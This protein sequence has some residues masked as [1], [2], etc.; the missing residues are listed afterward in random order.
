MGDT[1]KRERVVLP[2]IRPIPQSVKN[3]KTRRNSTFAASQASFNRH[4]S[5]PKI[6][7]KAMSGS[8][9][10]FNVL[11]P[12]AIE[13]D[14]IIPSKLRV[15]VYSNTSES[16]MMKQAKREQRECKPLDKSFQEQSFN[17]SEAYT[18]TPVILV[19]EMIGGI[20]VLVLSNVSSRISFTMVGYFL[21]CFLTACMQGAI[22]KIL[23]KKGNPV[24]SFYYVSSIMF[25]MV[26]MGSEESLDYILYLIW[27][28]SMLTI[29]LQSHQHRVWKHMLSCTI[30]NMIL[31]HFCKFIRPM[32]DFFCSTRKCPTPVFQKDIIVSMSNLIIACAF[33]A[34]DVYLHKYIPEIVEEKDELQ[35]LVIDNLDLQHQ[36]RVANFKNES[37]II[38]PLTR[39]IEVLI[40]LQNKDS[41][42]LKTSSDITSILEMLNSDRLFQPDFFEN[43]GDRD[44]ANFL[45]DVLQT[46]KN[47]Y[48]RPRTKS[49]VQVPSFPQKYATA[50]QIITLLQSSSDRFF[51]VFDLEVVSEGHALYYLASN[52]FQEHDLQITL[53]I[54]E[55]LFRHWLLKMETGYDRKNPYH[56]STHAA[57]VTHSLHYFITRDILKKKLSPEDIFSAMIAAISHDYMHPGFTNAFLVT[58]RNPLALR[59]NDQSVLEQFHSA[60]VFEIFSQPEYD[61][62]ATLASDQK[63]HIREL[64]TSMILAT[65]MAFHFE[66][67][68]KFKSKLSSNSI[69]LDNKNDRKLV[70][71]MAIK[72]SDVNNLSKPLH[73]SRIW[74]Q[75]IMEEF[76]KQGDE[77]RSRGLPISMF[78][79]RL[80]TDI[81]KCQLVILIDTGIY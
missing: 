73:I 48:L 57:D 62:L 20:V 69:N 79:D 44:V 71:N 4:E 46:R 8:A 59:Y 35:H 13:R 9:L 75:L 30:L 42:P 52:I 77:E 36:L 32:L 81:P 19:F 31:F 10:L 6:L 17:M 33:I 74:T 25:T 70:L 5:K 63:L 58:T 64:V 21:I 60:S 18:G 37:D 40:S 47:T 55:K 1:D 24:N 12:G 76:F 50:S 72:C 65:D 14:T 45:H 26:Y 22:W 66:W 23:S 16:L 7:G 11:K 3:L 2:P 61:I 68:S 53:G 49:N 15:N 67:L 56:N 41:V 29:L 43:T 39:A 27:N 34:H 38:A 78:M 80:S 51:N 54:N 28:V